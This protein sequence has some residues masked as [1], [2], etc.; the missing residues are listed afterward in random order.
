MKKAKLNKNLINNS[1]K[2]VQNG[3]H[4]S[5]Y[6]VGLSIQGVTKKRDWLYIFNFYKKFET[7]Q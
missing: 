7:I 5:T 2:F 6:T 1:K 4:Y 3:L